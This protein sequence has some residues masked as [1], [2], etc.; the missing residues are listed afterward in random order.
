MIV[1]PNAPVVASGTQIAFRCI[2]TSTGA[3]THKFLKNGVVLNTGDSDNSH[4][5]NAQVGDTGSYTC[6][7]VLDGVDSQQSSFHSV[8][9]VGEFV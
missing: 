8:T 9:V 2:T 6:I 3:L 1:S 5:I 7:A 4:V